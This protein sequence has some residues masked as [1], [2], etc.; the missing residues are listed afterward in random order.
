MQGPGNGKLT[1]AALKRIAAIAMAADHFAYAVLYY[2]YDLPALRTGDPS[3]PMLARI[4]DL[5]RGFGRISYPIF[6]FLIVEGF[7][8]TRNV[9][10]YIARI[11]VFALL[12]EVPFDLCFYGKPVSWETQNVLVTFLLGLL[13]LSA[14]HAIRYRASLASPL[15]AVLCAAVIAASAGIA[16][17]I[18]CDY[19]LPGILLIAFFYWFKSDRLFSLIGG[20]VILC[21][22]DLF[23]LPAVFGFALLYFYNGEKG[24]QNRWAFY[25]FYPLHLLLLRGLFF[26]L[27]P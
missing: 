15:R 8:K 18:K 19:D 3:A 9:R 26:L 22:W 16:F 11:A 14:L 13:M 10:R 17:L 27:M 24:K 21:P 4:Y 12:S 6:A 7:L 20:A 2:V 25:L 23:E 1:A 5:L